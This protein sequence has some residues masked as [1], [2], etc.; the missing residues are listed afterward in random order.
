LIGS[1]LSFDGVRLPF[2]LSPPALGAQTAEILGGEAKG[3]T[4]SDSKTPQKAQA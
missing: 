4:N 1:P 2:R 3:E